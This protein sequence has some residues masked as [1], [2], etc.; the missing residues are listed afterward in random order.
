LNASPNIVGV[1]KLRVKRWSGLVVRMGQ[2]RNAYKIFVG[3]LTGRDNPENLC[4]DG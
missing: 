3:H 4:A 1:I 2:M